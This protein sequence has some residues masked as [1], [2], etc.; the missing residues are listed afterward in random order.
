MGGLNF[1]IFIF[2]IQFL[3]IWEWLSLVLKRLLFFYL[4]KH[5]FYR[6]VLQMISENLN[7]FGYKIYLYKLV[8]SWFDLTT[9]LSPVPWYS[10][11][12][13]LKGERIVVLLPLYYKLDFL[14]LSI[15]L[16]LKLKFNIYLII[17]LSKFYLCKCILRTNLSHVSRIF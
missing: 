10:S 6:L 3:C 11:D 8:K 2:R 17:I 9:R 16:I 14:L 7:C 13:A 12:C 1:L 15:R 4:Y 5:S